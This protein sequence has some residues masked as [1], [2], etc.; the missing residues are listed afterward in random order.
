MQEKKKIKMVKLQPKLVWRQLK[1]KKEDI[2]GESTDEEMEQY[3][4]KLYMHDGIMP[5]TLNIETPY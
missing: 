4:C 1:H 2:I 3:V 5:M